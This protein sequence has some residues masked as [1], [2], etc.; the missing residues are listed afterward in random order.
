MRIDSNDTP[1]FVCRHD[2]NWLGYL[3]K[4]VDGQWIEVGGGPI[5][6]SYTYWFSMDF[7]NN[8]NPYL[9]WSMDGNRAHVTKYENDEWVSLGEVSQQTVYY[10]MNIGIN[11]D[12]KVFVA[13]NSN[14]TRGIDVYTFENEEWLNI[15]TNIG[16]CTTKHMDMVMVEG[17][18]T[19]VYSDETQGNALSVIHYD[20][21][22]WEYI[23]PRAYTEGAT[24][25]PQIALR[26]T[27]YYVS[28]VEDDLG[29]A[30]SVMKYQLPE[31]PQPPTAIAEAAAND[32]YTCY[33][34]VA[35]STIIIESKVRGEAK[36]MNINGSVVM[37]T[38]ISEGTN[39][40]EVRHL[41]HGM[42]IIDINGIKTKIIR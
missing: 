7:D 40:I 29:D 41:A 34:T 21:E 13:F 18:P 32:I 22:A 4:L 30:I 8:D 33:P 42:Y 23:G 19:I 20:G 31:P 10:Y 17:Y 27:T 28:F 1:Y 12:N 37:S 6:S 25:Y 26:D 24:S 11:E 2:G 39:E 14:G 36:I 3:H 16:D 5:N 35:N 15:G 9:L 38:N